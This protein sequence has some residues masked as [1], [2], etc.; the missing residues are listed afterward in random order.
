MFVLDA[1]HQAAAILAAQAA[2]LLMVE[3]DAVADALIP[4]RANGIHVQWTP[5]WAAL[6]T[7]YNPVRPSV[8]ADVDGSK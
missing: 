3:G 4:Q 7:S 2:V 8:W 1:I 5:T 6:A